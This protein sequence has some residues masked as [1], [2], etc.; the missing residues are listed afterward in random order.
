MA[1]LRRQYST[2]AV[3]SLVTA[4]VIGVIVGAVSEGVKAID[5]NNGSIEYGA[6]TVDQWEE[7]LLTG[8]AFLFGAACS[9]LAGYIGMYISVRSNSRTASA[10]TR[11]SE[12]ITVALRGGRLRLSRRRF[13]L[14]GVSSIFLLYTQALGNDGAIGP[15]S[16]SASVLA[17]ASSPSCPARRWYLH[18]AADVS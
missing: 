6:V 13:S 2:I 8:L 12:A 10:A 4:V 14:I 11:S 15:S 5:F 7:G 17:L 3:L 16:S 1:F 18:L 9:A